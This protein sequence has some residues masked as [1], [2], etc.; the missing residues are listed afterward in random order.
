MIVYKIDKQSQDRT[1]T[2][3]REMER[4]L[5]EIPRTLELLQDALTQQGSTI[6]TPSINQYRSELEQMINGAI[7]LTSNINDNTQRLVSISEQ[8]SKHLV[9]IED[10]FGSALR[11]KPAAAA[12]NQPQNTLQV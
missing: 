8:T 7:K 4:V 5:S 11:T 9:A 1:S 6:S 3:I 10:H 2:Q 12:V